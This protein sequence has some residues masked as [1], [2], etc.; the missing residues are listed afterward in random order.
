MAGGQWLR[1]ELRRLFLAVWRST[2]G[3]AVGDA[4]GTTPSK[5]KAA[6]HDAVTTPIAVEKAGYVAQRSL[7][8]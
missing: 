2:E 4:E 6:I 1:M 3:T 8:L 7:P 5:L